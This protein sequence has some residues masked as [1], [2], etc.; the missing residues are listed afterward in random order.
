MYKIYQS[1][2]VVLNYKYWECKKKRTVLKSI[3][4]QTE[5]Q[6]KACDNFISAGYSIPT[7]FIIAHVQKYKVERNI[8]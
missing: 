3:F 7:N 5:S 2:C 4:H 1:H 6:K 8:E